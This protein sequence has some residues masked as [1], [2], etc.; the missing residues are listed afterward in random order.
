MGASYFHDAVDGDFFAEI[1]PRFRER[2]ISGIKITLSY[3]HQ[4]LISLVE[5]HVSIFY[6]KILNSAGTLREENAWRHLKH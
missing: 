2:V 1:K 6:K 3:L 5:V 4:T